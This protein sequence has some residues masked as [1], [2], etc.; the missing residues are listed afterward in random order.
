VQVTRVT[1]HFFGGTRRNLQEKKGSDMFRAAQGICPANEIHDLRICEG[2]SNPQFHRSLRF[3]FCAG[4]LGGAAVA[5]KHG[6][7]NCGEP[8][9]PQ[10]LTPTATEFEQMA[11]KLNLEPNEYVKSVHLRE[12]AQ[13]NRYFKYVPEP[14]LRAWGLRVKV[15]L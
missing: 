8:E 2:V 6:N 15:T 14:L 4:L 10:A 5:K 12:W 3:V 11:Q 13:R 9:Q 1:I 7:P